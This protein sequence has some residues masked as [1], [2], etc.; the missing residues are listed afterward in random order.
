MNE[1]ITHIDREAH[2]RYLKHQIDEY[3]SSLHEKKVQKKK[4]GT[5]SVWDGN[6]RDP[7]E[8]EFD[9]YIDYNDKNVFHVTDNDDE[10][11]KT[12]KCKCCGGTKFNVGQ[13]SWFTAIK[14]IVCNWE[15]GWDEG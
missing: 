4:A 7:D 9:E 6:F 5:T 3:E 12:F 10:S 2:K 8:V 15:Y 1:L 13:G 14:C 11:I